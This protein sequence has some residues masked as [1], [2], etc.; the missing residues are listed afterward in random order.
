MEKIK[1]SNNL[2]ATQNGSDQEK[3]C[4]ILLCINFYKYAQ[5]VCSVML[6]PERWLSS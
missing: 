3:Q 6:L 1:T 2:L 5:C 4:L